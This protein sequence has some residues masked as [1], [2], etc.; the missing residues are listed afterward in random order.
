LRKEN[1][2][3]VGVLRVEGVEEEVVHI[4][5]LREFWEAIMAVEV[6]S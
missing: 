1:P 6:S 2:L 5:Q 3:G 4:D